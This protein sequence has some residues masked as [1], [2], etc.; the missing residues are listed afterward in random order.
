[1]PVFGENDVEETDGRITVKGDG[2]SVSVDRT[3]GALDSFEND[4]L[5]MI[6]EGL[7]PNYWRA[8]TDNDAKEGVDGTWKKPM[9]GLSWTART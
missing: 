3:T 5:E 4:G 2:W 7:Q 8:Y 9:T 1:M 6:Q